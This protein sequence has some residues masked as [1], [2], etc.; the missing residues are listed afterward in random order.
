M[1]KRD[2]ST[3]RKISWSWQ[4]KIQL[5]DVIP[6]VWRRLACRKPS[7][8]PNCI[9]SF[10][11]TSVGRTV[12][13][14]SLSSAAFDTANPIRILTT[15]SGTSMSEASSCT[16]PLASTRAALTIFMTSGTT[17]ITW[18]WSRINTSIRSG[19]RQSAASTG[20]MPAR[21][22]MSAAPFATRNF[23]PQS[24]IPAT[25]NTRLIENGPVVAL[26]LAFLISTRST[27]HSAKSKRDQSLRLVGMKPTASSLRSVRVTFGDLRA[28]SSASS[29]IDCAYLSRMMASP[30]TL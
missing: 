29:V 3:S 25:R 1:A 19:G 14:M 10:K 26:T 4:L 7:R 12:I 17:G 16:R 22:K 5:L 15:N 2:A 24:G 20:R 30:P 9:K 8:C 13:Y 18:C 28:V 11:P 27:G 6:T 21:P 23:S